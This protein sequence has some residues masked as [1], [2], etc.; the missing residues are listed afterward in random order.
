MEGFDLAIICE[1]DR[2]HGAGKGSMDSSI[3]N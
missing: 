3:E 1:S 2:Y